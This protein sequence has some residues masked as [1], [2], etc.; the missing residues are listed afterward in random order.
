M[1]IPSRWLSDY[2]DLEVSEAAI[3]RLAERLTLAGLEVEEIRPTGTLRGVVVG[4]VTTCRPHPNSDHLSLCGV[5]VG[6]ET[7]DVVCGAANVRTGACVPLARIGAELPGGF[8]IEKRKVRGEVSNGM[9]CSKAELG[10]E[11]KSDGIWIFDE[12]LGLSLGADLAEQLEYDDFVLDIK[13]KSNRTDCFGVYGVAREVAAVL[14]LPLRALD[15][16]C[17]ETPAEDEIEIEIEDPHDTPR[18][19][20]RRMDAVAVG[21]SPLRLQHRLIKAGMRPVSNAVDATN[22][23]MIELGHPIHPFDADRLGTK[24]LIRRARPSESFRTLD[25]IDRTLD[26]RALLI[27]DGGRPI[28][29]AGVMGGEES[30]IREDTKRILLEVATFHHRTI[31]ESS[32][33]VGLQSEAS[34]RFERGV[35]PEGVPLVAAR[36]AHWMQRLTGCRVTAGLED[37]YPAPVRPRTVSLR[38]EKACRLLGMAIDTDEVVHLL[39]R[40]QIPARRTRGGADVVTAEI[41]WF[42][43]DLEREVDLIEEV[44]RLHGYDRLEAVAPR[45]VVRV[46]RKDI[47]ELGKDRIRASLVALG[48]DEVVNDGFDD[49]RWREALSAPDDDLLRVRNPMGAAQAALRGSLLPGLLATVETNLRRGVDGGAVFELG[50]VF[51]RA[52]G[53][54]DALGGALFGRT[55]LPLSGKERVSLSTAKGLLDQLLASLQIDGV[56]VVADAE[57]P[58]LHPGR[59]GTWRRAGQAIGVFGELHPSLRDQF[60][61]PTTVLVFEFALASLLAAAPPAR[62]RPIPL[63]PAAKRDLSLTVPLAV[64]EAR[65]R[66]VLASEPAVESILLYDLYVGEQVGEGKK[67]LT[68]EL[69]LRAPERTLTD[70]EATAIVDRLAG[71]LAEL[72]V[73]VRAA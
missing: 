72:D 70:A 25:G 38:P 12:R 45:A 51:S 44:G 5:D 7:L 73:H 52:R 18:Y 48:M 50:R 15:V 13:V 64:E 30:E 63:L 26:P 4:R 31:R 29:L 59:S 19:A 22:Y 24:I 67:S 9:I 49:R 69:T 6:G 37:A 55:G 58:F 8:R 47:A 32:R 54:T 46:G 14:D 34:Q 57:R 17:D 68:Y 16:S 33:S 36:T 35:G 53:E 20:L 23:V 11:E 71:R 3:A 41:P 61:V 42:R 56:E 27:T 10:L 21:P 40:L 39:Q 65:V 2:V 62:Y 28:A 60:A 43:P 1:G 66:A